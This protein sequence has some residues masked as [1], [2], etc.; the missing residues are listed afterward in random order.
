MLNV[1]ETEKFITEMN[2]IHEDEELSSGSDST[3]TSS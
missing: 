3:R 2:K 1:R